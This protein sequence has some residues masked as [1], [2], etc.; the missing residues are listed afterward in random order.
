VYRD[1]L[2]GLVHTIAGI[3]HDTSV[4]IEAFVA[5]KECEPETG[6]PGVLVSTIRGMDE[7]C[8]CAGSIDPLLDRQKP[9]GA[10]R[11]PHGIFC[12]YVVS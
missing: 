1:Y 5:R 9:G 3:Y 8:Q 11:H 7:G 2:E 12:S 4:V 10:F 6:E